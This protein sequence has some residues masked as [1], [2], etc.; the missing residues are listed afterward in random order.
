MHV[1]NLLVG[2]CGV[3]NIAVV[4]PTALPKPIMYVLGHYDK[5]R[6][7]ETIFV[8]RPSNGLREPKPT[9]VFTQERLAT[10]TG[11]R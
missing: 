8:A 3:Q 6:H 9:A 11:E 7:V 10:K 4:A 1:L 2:G 5:R